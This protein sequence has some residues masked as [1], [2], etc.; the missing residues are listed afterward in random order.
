MQ[1]LIKISED[2]L[3]R[4][5][6]NVRLGLGTDVDNAIFNGSCFPDN[7]ELRVFTNNTNG[8]VAADD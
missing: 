6:R 4:I 7:V 1:I 3:Q 5:R 8:E 2:D